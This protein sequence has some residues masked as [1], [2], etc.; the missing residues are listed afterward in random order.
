MS[1]NTKTFV[2]RLLEHRLPR[3]KSISFHP[4]EN[5]LLLGLR[6]TPSKNAAEQAPP[7]MIFDLTTNQIEEYAA[8]GG[9]VRAT[10]FNPNG[11]L[12]ATGGDDFKIQIWRWKSREVISTIEKH[13]D[14]IRCL[15][16][17]PIQ[18]WLLSACDDQTAR[19][20]DA[21]GTELTAMHHGHYVMCARWH[22]TVS[23]LLA[24]PLPLPPAPFIFDKP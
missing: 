20:F 11:E 10:C 23:S 19:V 15:E 6:R 3:V 8:H 21:Q 17:H 2:K 22:P 9:I 4:E 18:P 13:Q 24:S 7:V 12:F 5:F 16:Y 1:S 14:Y